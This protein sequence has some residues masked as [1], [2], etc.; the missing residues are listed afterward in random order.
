[1]PKFL[2]SIWYVIILSISAFIGL[3]FGFKN[4]VG[5]TT[6]DS[7]YISGAVAIIIFLLGSKNN[8]ERKADEER[9]KEKDEIYEELEKRPDYKYVDDHD[10]NILKVLE[11]HVIESRNINKT[12]TNLIESIDGNVKILLS[13][14][15]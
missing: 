11:Q 10:Q 8:I 13:K 4:F 6:N 3:Y 1:M 5:A 12:Q 15:K 7:A 2:R 9:K 14:L